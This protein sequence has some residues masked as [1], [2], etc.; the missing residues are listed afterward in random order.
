MI[1]QTPAAEELPIV[2]T[3]TEDEKVERGEEN[4][5]LF[6]AAEQVRELPDGYAF[7][8]AGSDAAANRLLQFVL[9]ERDC[10]L[11]FTFELVFE[12]DKGPIWVHL[13]GSAAVKE[14]VAS[15]LGEIIAAHA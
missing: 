3:L 1:E 7:R 4:G 5:G 9:A 2:C 6:K 12:P 13:R 14:F 10:C 8:F 11:F 15:N